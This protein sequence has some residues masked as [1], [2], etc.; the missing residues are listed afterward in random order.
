MKMTLMLC[1]HDAYNGY[2][3]SVGLWEYIGVYM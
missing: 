1:V 2:L 3:I